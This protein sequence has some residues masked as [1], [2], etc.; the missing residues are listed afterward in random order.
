MVT[1]VRSSWST[2]QCGAKVQNAY[3]LKGKQVSSHV[4]FDIVILL[5]VVVVLDMIIILIRTSLINLYPKPFYTWILALHKDG[6]IFLDDFTQSPKCVLFCHNVCERVMDISVCPS[7]PVW[8]WRNPPRHQHW[9]CPLLTAHS[10]CWPWPMPEGQL[11]I[12][13]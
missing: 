6:C 8:Q 4:L 5:L 11:V 1:T 2:S 3:T 10:L 9:D 12:Q 13:S 7:C